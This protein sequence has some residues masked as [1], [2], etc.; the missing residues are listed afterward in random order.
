MRLNIWTETSWKN[1]YKWALGTW[2]GIPHYSSSGKWDLKPQFDITTHTRVT[3]VEE[4]MTA[5]VGEHVTSLKLSCF[6]GTNVKRKFGRYTLAVSYQIKELLTI[7]P[8]ISISSLHLV[9]IKTYMNRRTHPHTFLTA[10]FILTPNWKQPHYCQMDTF[11]HI[12]TTCY[13]LAV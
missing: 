12:G 10:P 13:C 6:A 8:I 4:T 3:N 9:K 11:W 2:R 5:N 7:G 1:A